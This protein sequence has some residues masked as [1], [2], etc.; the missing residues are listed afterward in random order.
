MFCSPCWHFL[1]ECWK[2]KYLLLL[3]MSRGFVARSSRSDNPK[4]LEKNVRSNE[5]THEFLTCD[6]S[7]RFLKVE[8]NHLL[9]RRIDKRGKRTLKIIFVA[10]CDVGIKHIV[11]ASDS[12]PNSFS[13]AAPQISSAGTKQWN[14][15]VLKWGRA[16]IDSKLNT[17]LNFPVSV[18]WE[19]KPLKQTSNPDDLHSA[20]NTNS[21]NF[22][23]TVFVW[24]ITPLRRAIFLLLKSVW[25][26]RGLSSQHF[27]V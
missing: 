12:I 5:K 9:L 26:R 4:S 25:P 8:I 21:V 17:K 10:Q 11:K 14:P 7:I 15:S 16:H 19:S 1:L 20:D 23:L 24:S 3:L 6:S 22:S 27:G 13:T 2:N 18:K